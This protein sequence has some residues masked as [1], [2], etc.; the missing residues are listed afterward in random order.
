MKKKGK[1]KN[2]KDLKHLDFSFLDWKVS[3]I[4]KQVEMVKKMRDEFYE[5]IFA[6]KDSERN[7]QNTIVAMDNFNREFGRIFGLVN[8]IMNLHTDKTMRELAQKTEVALGEL[9]VEISS[10]YE[11]FK[12]IKAYTDNTRVQKQENLGEVEKYIISEM[13]KGYKRSGM[14]L[15]AKERKILEK[16][17]KEINKLSSEYHLEYNNSFHKGLWFADAELLGVSKAYKDSWQSRMKKNESEELKEYFVTLASS[18]RQIIAEKCEISETRKKFLE[19]GLSV[20]SLQNLKRLQKAIAIRYEVAQMLGYKS[21]SDFSLETELVDTTAKLNKFMKDLDVALQLGVKKDWQKI[22]EEA[23]K[24]K[25][26]KIEL[27]DR[28]YLASK[29]EEAQTSLSSEFISEYF[30]YEHVLETTWELLKNIFG[31]I[32][33]EVKFDSLIFHTD[34]RLYE[35]RDQKNAKILGYSLLDLFPREGKYGHAC[36]TDFDINVSGGKYNS[37]ALICN[38]QNVTK[39]NKRLISYEDLNTLLHEMGHMLHAISCDVPY[40][41]LHMTHVSN[42]FVEIP[43]QFLENFLREEKTLKKF[44]KHYKTGK[45]MNKKELQILK[46]KEKFFIASMWNRQAIYVTADVE[47]HGKNAPKYFE[48]EKSFQN[49]KKLYEKVFKSREKTTKLKMFESQNVL[50]NFGHIMGGYEAKYYSYIASY[51]YMCDV[52][53]S[54]KSTGMTKKAGLKYRKEMLSVGASLPES[55]ILKNYLGREVSLKPFKDRISG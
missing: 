3:D 37:R 24:E 15:P 49:L 46:D 19:F 48:S 31:I 8:I 17:K 41:A 28:G 14:L 22:Q 36:V 7:F 27:W 21:F 5:T 16:K 29:Y 26:T 2:V 10:N 34:A 1:I 33:A 18:N 12:A 44:T 53:E 9:A 23:K 52:W 39:D 50:A 20:G 51:A 13:I 11:L 30:E 25:L 54:F 38:F 43:S 4:E 47:I 45:P 32:V 55:K 40:D 42:D 35:W 6:I